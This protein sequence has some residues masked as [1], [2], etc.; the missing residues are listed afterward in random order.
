MQFRMQ[1]PMQLRPLPFRQFRPLSFLLFSLLAGCTSSTAPSFLAVL[2]VQSSEP[3]YVLAASTPPRFTFRHHG[4]PDIVISGCPEAPSAI[5]ERKDETGK[6]VE[7]ATRGIICLGI[8]TVQ[9]DTLSAGEER[10]FT[11]PAWRAGRYRLRVLA[12]PSPGRPERTVL[13]NEFDVQ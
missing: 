10:E 5:L 1:F 13:S 3:S 7:E 9:V 8:Y 11:M 4:G 2:R 6:W 12:G